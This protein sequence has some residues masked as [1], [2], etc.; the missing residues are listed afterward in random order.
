MVRRDQTGRR[1]IPSRQ[2]LVQSQAPT[3]LSPEGGEGTS[4]HRERLE[5]AQAGSGG[6][7]QAAGSV[8]TVRGEPAVPMERLSTFS[9]RAS[10]PGPSRTSTAGEASPVPVV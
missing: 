10:H 4:L 2:S 3:P 9:T 1:D 7:R 8:T 5:A 6:S